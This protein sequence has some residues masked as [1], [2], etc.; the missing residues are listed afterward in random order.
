[1]SCQ[2]RSHPSAAHT[3]IHTHMHARTDTHTL[4]LY[5]HTHAHTYTHAHPLSC[6]FQ[7][8]EKSL[9]DQRRYSLIDP[10]SSSAPELLRL[11]H[12]LISTE[13]ALRDALDQAQQVERLVEAMRS[14]PDKS[15]VSWVPPRSGGRA[16]A[17]PPGSPSPRGPCLYPEELR[18]RAEMQPCPESLDFPIVMGSA[19]SSGLS[20]WCWW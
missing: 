6:C 5:T 2:R 3:R 13:D 19:Q 17:L 14:C 7:D 4:L 18:R 12:Q 20:R 10:S 16:S 11:Q 1:M 8:K 9:S 15:Q